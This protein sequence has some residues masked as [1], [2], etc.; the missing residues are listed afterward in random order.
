MIL[1][2]T[3][4]TKPLDTEHMYCLVCRQDQTFIA[5]YVA[6]HKLIWR[7]Q[8]CTWPI[9]WTPI[10]ATEISVTIGSIKDFRIMKDTKQQ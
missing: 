8:V 4:E 6:P 5:Y 9:M 10:S 1:D 2:M 7:C 3:K